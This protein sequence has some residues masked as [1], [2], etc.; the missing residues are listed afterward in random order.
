MNH[1][2]HT[3]ELPDGSVIKGEVDYRGNLGRRFLLPNDLAGKSVADFG[4]WNG[5][6]AIEAKKRGAS[7][8][9]ALDRWWPQIE[10]TAL[11]EYGI[12]YR[13]S[14]DLDFPASLDDLRECFDVVLFY[15]ILYHLKNPYMGLLTASTCCK[16]GGM[17]IVESAIGQGKAQGL[18]DSVPA[19]WVID[20]VHDGDPTNYF[21]PNEG[22]IVQLGKMVGLEKVA[23]CREGTRIGV[24]FNKNSV[25]KK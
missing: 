13:Y 1:W 15:G 22:A 20:T 7:H 5:Y 11:K 8:V 18:P 2:Y 3:I 19:L 23:S 4:T 24:L 9:L 17:V 21:M 25:S 14:G 6:W 16:P 12:E 10:E